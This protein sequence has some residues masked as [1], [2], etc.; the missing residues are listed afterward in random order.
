[1]EENQETEEAGRRED[2]NQFRC[3]VHAS[4]PHKKCYYTLQTC[5]NKKKLKL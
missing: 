2:K 1:M 3:F 4:T 5:T